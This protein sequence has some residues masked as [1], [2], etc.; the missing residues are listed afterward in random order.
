MTIL[1]TQIQSS[2]PD[3]KANKN[4]HL[5]LAKTY[6]ELV[7]KVKM[8]GGAKAQERH[9]SRGKLMA[10][11]RI[12]AILDEDSSFLELSTLAGHEVYSSET[13]SAGVVTG[14]GKVNGTLCVFVANDATVKGG[15]YFPLTVKKHLRA[16]EIALKNKLPCI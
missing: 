15:T 16:Q 7:Q 14:I 12:E 5:N 6:D 11:G 10:R 8:G 3:F 13:N 1:S 9:L 2:N 4:F